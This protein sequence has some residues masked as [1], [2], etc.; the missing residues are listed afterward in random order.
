MT[1]RRFQ[2]TFT[3]GKMH[4][5]ELELWFDK[6]VSDGLPVVP[7]TRD[8]VERMLSATRLDRHELIG[9]V[10]PNYGRATVEKIAVNAV[11]AGCRSE[12]LPVVI[13]AVEAACDPVF[14]LHGHSGT[15]NA[16]SP[17]I[18][19]NGSARRVLG[20]NCAAGVFGPG[21]RA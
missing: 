11:M 8:R 16:A 4:A 6:G 20:V 15:T 9:Q 14:N 3:R 10:A 2:R 18:I 7:P 13:A 5:D 19:V 1:A 12:Y 21:H 17:L